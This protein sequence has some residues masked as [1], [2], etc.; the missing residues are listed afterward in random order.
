MPLA[1]KCR[2]MI[3]VYKVYADIP[4]CFFP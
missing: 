1:A 2:P 3:L 4:L